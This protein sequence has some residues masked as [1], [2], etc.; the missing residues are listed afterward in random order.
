MTYTIDT[1]PAKIYFKIFETGDTSLL[2]TDKDIDTDKLW[3]KIELQT[4]DYQKNTKSDKILYLSKKI[5]QF[6]S[7]L[8]AILNTVNYLKSVKNDDESID[9]LLSYGYKITSKTINEDLERIERESNAIEIK[10]DKYTSDL[11]K[12]KPKNTK[13]KSSFE[14]LYMSYLAILE[15][16]FKGSNEVTFLEF[17]GLEKQVLS[18]IKALDGRKR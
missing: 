18:K 3:Q 4:L 6:S 17:M 15:F 9:L 12:V 7:R 2:S 5:Q 14:D 10:I 8:N 11:E 16:G 13:D 1:I